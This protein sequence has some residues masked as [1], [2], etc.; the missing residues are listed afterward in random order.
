MG[1]NQLQKDFKKRKEKE[2][3]ALGVIVLDTKSMDKL[4]CSSMRCG[5]NEAMHRIHSIVSF[6]Y[7]THP[8]CIAGKV[9]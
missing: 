9:P 6:Y 7:C 8:L 4:Y 2:L 3:Q 1:K 5:A